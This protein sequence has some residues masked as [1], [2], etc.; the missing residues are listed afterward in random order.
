M[1]NDFREYSAAFHDRQN[2]LMHYGVKGMKWDPSK[3]RRRGQTDP[4]GGP[5]VPSLAGT[6][7]HY[8]PLLKKSNQF[9]RLSNSDLKKIANNESAAYDEKKLYDTKNGYASRD[10]AS[11]ASDIYDL[12]KSGELK[13]NHKGNVF[14]DALK[15]AKDE[16][17]KKSLTGIAKKH[18]SRKLEKRRNKERTNARKAE[19]AYRRGG[20]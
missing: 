4:T 7:R 10:L 15:K 19:Q 5:G 20:H 3:R 12:R 8:I 2:S 9:N 6:E 14:S 17:K 1:S 18:A 11:I 13:S 16:K